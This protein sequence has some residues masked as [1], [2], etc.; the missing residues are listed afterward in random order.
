MWDAPSH[1][2]YLIDCLVAFIMGRNDPKITLDMQKILPF[3]CIFMAFWLTFNSFTR[4]QTQ[5]DLRGTYYYIHTYLSY[6]LAESPLPKK[7]MKFILSIP[8]TYLCWEHIPYKKGMKTGS[9]I[10]SINDKFNFPTAM[11]Q[12]Q[13]IIP[14]FFNR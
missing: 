12:L 4:Q 9:C 10:L 2:E 6:I 8:H 11:R 1:P 3:Y 14:R 13:M 7:G 5:S